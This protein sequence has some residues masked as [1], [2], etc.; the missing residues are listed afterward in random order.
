[1]PPK[2]AGRGSDRPNKKARPTSLEDVVADAKPGAAGPAAAKTGR[3]T[4]TVQEVRERRPCS[5]SCCWLLQPSS[6]LVIVSMAR[7]CSGGSS[8]KLIGCLR[9]PICGGVDYDLERCCATV[10]DLG[11]RQRAQDGSHRSCKCWLR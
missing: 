5:A 7:R 10:A 6:V 11:M 8:W 2:K 1:M 9:S 4:L 3:N